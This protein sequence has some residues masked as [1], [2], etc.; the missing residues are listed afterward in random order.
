M[1]KDNS[2]SMFGFFTLWFG[3]SVSVAEILTGGLLA[4]IGFRAGLLTI[5]LGHMI[6]T[7]ILVL[8]GIIGTEER[9]PSIA[10][11]GT[12]FGAYGTCLFSVLNVLQLLGWTAVMIISIRGKVGE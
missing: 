4:P 12:T 5:V 1:N 3:A 8:G 11:T 10:S 9:L 6:G 2:I 7:G